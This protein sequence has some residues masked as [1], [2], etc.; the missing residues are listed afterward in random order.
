MKQTDKN[1]NIDIQVVKS[2]YLWFNVNDADTKSNQDN[3]I[4]FNFDYEKLAGK[5]WRFY[6]DITLKL[7]NID[8]M[9]RTAFQ[10][11]DEELNWDD[12]FIPDMITPMVNTAVQKC[13]GA[14]IQLCKS[15]KIP[16]DENIE[17]GEEIILSISNAIIEQYSGHRKLSD[18]Q[19][20]YLLNNT[21]L[22]IEPGYEVIVTIQCV[23]M[24]I[25]EFLFNQQPTHKIHNHKTF[26]EIVPIPR[27]ITI[28]M[29]S[30]EIEKQTV[31][32]KPFNYL[33]KKYDLAK[34]DAL[35]LVIDVEGHEKLILESIDFE[36][37]KPDVII[38]EHAHMSYDTHRILHRLLTNFG[39]SI[40]LDKYDTVAV[41]K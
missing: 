30:L 4:S 18:K 9:V 22:V 7:Q 32:G 5:I 8:N 19:N 33:V 1:K 17:I 24:I 34:K 20:E 36:M 10:F 2:N 41:I 39:Y 11:I 16:I 12:I 37:V 35:L 13:Q 27:Y 31:Q 15:N 29:N 28:K 6:I 21:G 26:G 3:D 14:F 40:Y 25:D 38:Y 23:F